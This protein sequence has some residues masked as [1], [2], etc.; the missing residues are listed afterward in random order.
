MARVP[1]L[2]AALVAFA[3]LAPAGARAQVPGLAPPP[4]PA[5]EA[6]SAPP[7]AAAAPDAAASPDAPGA[8]PPAAAAADGAGAAARARALADALRDE[9]ARAA[10]I[11]ELERLAGGAAP[12]VPAPP[13]AEAPPGSPPADPAAATADA[14]AEAL[15]QHS[16]GRRLALYANE[17]AQELRDASRAFVNGVAATQ[18]RLSALW[19]G[20]EPMELL[21]AARGLVAVVAV[22]V[23]VYYVLRRALAPIIRG[24]S[25]RN[26]ATGLIRGVR[27]A[28]AVL[29]FDFAAV[30]VAWGVG[31]ALTFTAF[32]PVGEITVNQSLYLNAFLVVELVKAALHALLAPRADRLRFAPLSDAGARY[33]SGRLGGIVSL[34][35]YGLLLVTPIVDQTVSIF[36]GRAVQVLIYA[37]ALLWAMALVIRHRAAPSAWLTAKAEAERNDPTLRILAVVASVWHWPALTWL[38][39]LFVIAVSRSGAVGPV[40]AST[41][42]AL[43]IVAL[44]AGA[45]TLVARGARHGVRLPATVTAA[46]PLLEARVNLFLLRFLGALRFLI[47][48]ATLGTALRV[49]GVVD[50][51]ATLSGWLGQDFGAIVFEIGVTAVLAFAVWLAVA[52]W[53][54][55]RLNPER[56]VAPDPREQTLLSLLRN[57]ATV[58]IVVVA[59][60]SILSDLG[61]DVAPLIASAGVVGLAIGFGA[62]RLVQDVITGIFIQFENA[63]NVG[64]VVTVGGI[65]GVVEK[66]TIRSVSLRDVGGVFHIIPFS[67]VDMVS[68]FNRGFAFHVADLGV[69]YDTDLAT[70]KGAIL[71]AFDDVKADPAHGRSIIGPIDWQGVTAFGDSAITLRARIRTRPGAQWSVGRAFNEAVKRRFDEAGVEIPFPQT[72]MWIRNEAGAGGEAP[73]AGAREARVGD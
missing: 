56:T 26:A 12:P 54:D 20:D 51:R 55:Y 39:V 71:A 8:A 36:T 25:E 29:A 52:S 41:G 58:A 5:A 65:S 57:A 72:T 38:I 45:S 37:A 32:G 9:G 30:V 16:I 64:D 35:G 59:A 48:A 50:L 17:A 47:F 44:G 22:T 23:G 4:P 14:V 18:R 43:G 60:M 13:G 6:G 1:V 49:A 66:L 24:F 40:L 21:Q 11:A 2:F 34:L 31:Y 27:L 67:S 7:A 46:V 63:I 61:L 19:R 69:A 33:W 10:L 53:V 70:A 68:N 42:A 15:P 28:V 3:A 73:P 62:Q